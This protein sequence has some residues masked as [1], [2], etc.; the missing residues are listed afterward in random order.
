MLC[1]LTYLSAYLSFQFAVGFTIVSGYTVGFTKFY[2]IDLKFIFSAVQ[3][4]GIYM[5]HQPRV[6]RHSHIECI[7]VVPDV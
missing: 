4:W 3:V 2:F 6:R 1:G 5:S 7:L